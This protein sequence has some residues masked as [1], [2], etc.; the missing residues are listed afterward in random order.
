VGGSF[1]R[2]KAKMRNREVGWWTEGI[3]TT[4][5]V[6][7]RSITGGRAWDD[8]GGGRGAYAVL[9]EYDGVERD[10]KLVA[11]ALHVRRCHGLHVQWNPLADLHAW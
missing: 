9:A 10:G 2:N 7:K 4:G 6:F 5:A 1:R 3:S 11:V 8:V